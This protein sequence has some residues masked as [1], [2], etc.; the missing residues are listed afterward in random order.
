MGAFVGASV[1]SRRRCSSSSS[2]C[3]SDNTRVLCDAVLARNIM[4]VWSV[5]QTSNVEYVPGQRGMCLVPQLPGYIS[6]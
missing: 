4:Q 2:R 1:G 6:R 3:V 5:T